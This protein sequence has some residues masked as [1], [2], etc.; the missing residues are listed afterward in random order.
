[1]MRLFVDSAT[2][3][4]KPRYRGMLQTVWGSA[5]NFME[6]YNGTANPDRMDNSANSF[7][8][9]IKVWNQ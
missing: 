3:E 1:M 8:A 4:M 6:S 7:K 9:L 2:K 5:K